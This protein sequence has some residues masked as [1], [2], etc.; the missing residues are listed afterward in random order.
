MIVFRFAVVLATALLIAGPRQGT[1]LTLRELIPETA[2]ESTGINKLAQSEREALVRAILQAH[3][4][5]L[6]HRSNGVY[7]IAPSVSTSMKAKEIRM[8][9]GVP[10]VSLR[11]AYRALV[12]VRS[13]L[14]NPLR[15]FYSNILELQQDA[16]NQLNIAGPK[17]HVYVFELD[18]D[19]RPTQKSHD[20][21]EAN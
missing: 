1:D 14:S 17:Y 18:E 6:L 11:S 19:F 8:R 13:A 5:L 3:T 12:V 21:F 4:N 9:T 2:W 7:V 10:E 15:G 20:S 16:D